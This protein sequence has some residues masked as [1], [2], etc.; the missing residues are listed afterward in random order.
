MPNYGNTVK[1]ALRYLLGNSDA[2]EI[3]DGFLAL[4]QDVDSKLTPYDSGLL[5]SRP[6]STAGT[7]GK[8]GRWYRATDTGQL[9]LDHGTGWYDVGSV[10]SAAGLTLGADVNLYRA[11]ANTLRT[12]D[13]FVA[14]DYVQAYSG[15][16]NKVTLGRIASSTAGAGLT[17]GSADDTNLFRS[18]AGALRT[19]HALDVVGALTKAGVAVVLTNDSRLSNARTPTAHAASHAV[20]GSDPIT[21]A[22]I[23]ALAG[24]G[25]V[26]RGRVNA[27]G[28]KAQGGTDFSVAR[29]AG[30]AAGGYTI[31]FT[32]D[33]TGVPTVIATAH[34]ARTAALDAA[35]PPAAGAANVLTFFGTNLSDATFDF[36]AIGI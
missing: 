11:A 7:P 1:H 14:S 19:D 31:D 27:D 33:F 20:G 15:T 25:R 16:A 34:G 32:P 26:V 28:T 5:S 36:I 4:A 8:A 30:Q 3:D 9:F 29:T 13:A 22:S 17:F 6:T 10:L 2:N 18:G 24:G 23:G 35:N 21:A 12:D